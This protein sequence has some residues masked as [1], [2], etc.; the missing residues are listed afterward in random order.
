MWRRVAQAVPRRA[1]FTLRLDTAVTPNGDP[2]EGCRNAEAGI[3]DS[4]FLDSQHITHGD[5][6]DSNYG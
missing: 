2:A 3:G 6:Y 5:D 4:R 1:R